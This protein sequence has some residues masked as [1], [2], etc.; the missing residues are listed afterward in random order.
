MLS[1]REQGQNDTNQHISSLVKWG[2]RQT[3]LDRRFAAS[4]AATTLRNIAR[5]M[6]TPV[7]AARLAE[8]AEK[9]AGR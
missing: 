9:M 7:D 6:T 3:D 8:C 1:D 5:G 2:A 4:N